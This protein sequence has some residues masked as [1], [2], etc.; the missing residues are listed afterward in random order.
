MGPRRLRRGGVALPSLQAEHHVFLFFLSR[1]Y[2][3]NVRIGT[4]PACDAPPSLPQRICTGLCWKR[5][6]IAGRGCVMQKKGP[7]RA[8]MCLPVGVGFLRTANAFVCTAIRKYNQQR[9]NGDKEDEA[10]IL[11]RH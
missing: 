3:G 10:S 1:A 2:V 5:K 8:G 6:E 9:Y 4:G 7:V 11:L